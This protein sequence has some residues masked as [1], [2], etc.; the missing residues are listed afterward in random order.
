MKTNYVVL[1]VLVFHL[2]V[3]LMIKMSLDDRRNKFGVQDVES[4]LNKD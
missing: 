2:V 3:V 1:D 4:R